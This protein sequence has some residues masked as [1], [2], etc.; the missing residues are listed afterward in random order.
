[1]VFAGPARLLRDGARRV[2]LS[3][4]Q[5]VSTRDTGRRPCRIIAQAMWSA[6]LVLSGTAD[7]LVN[8]TGFAVVLFSGIAGAALFVLRWREP[9]E[10][11]PFSAWGYPVAPGIFVIASALIVVNAVWRNP[12]HPVPASQSSW[13]ACRSTGICAAA[14]A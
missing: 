1:M 12:S 14:D 7:A 4:R 11:R 13:Q 2:V 8:Y 10:P 3:A 6:V 9:D 5:R